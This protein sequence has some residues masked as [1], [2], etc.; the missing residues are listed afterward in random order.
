MKTITRT[1]RALELPL[2]PEDVTQEGWVLRAMKPVQLVVGSHVRPGVGVLLSEHERHE[3]DLAQSSW[4]DNAVIPEALVLLVVGAK[5]QVSVRWRT[6]RKSAT[7]TKCLM[8]L[9]I[10]PL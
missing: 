10:P 6:I 9:P 5:S 8:V 2:L 1:Y 7:Y 3:V 4:A